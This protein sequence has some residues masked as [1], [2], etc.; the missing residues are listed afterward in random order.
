VVTILDLLLI[1][2][3]LESILLRYVLGLAGAVL[4]FYAMRHLLRR[5]RLFFIPGE[6]FILILYFTGTWLGPFVTRRVDLEATQGLV[7]IM[8]AGVLLMNLGIISIYDI[9][10]DSRLGIASMAHTLGRKAARNLI[11]ATALLVYLL[12]VMQFLVYG[13]D[14]NSGFALI[15]AG[16]A[17]IL[18]IILYLPSYFR[19][20]EQYRMVTDAILYMGFL[21]MLV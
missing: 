21:S 14:R 5:N 4:L 13:M 12:A 19:R 11:L 6:I 15:L 7:A 18:L 10:I 3:F 8:F 9:R 1:F 17:S 16:M 2:N 20:N